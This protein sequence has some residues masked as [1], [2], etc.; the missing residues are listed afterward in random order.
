MTIY[1]IGI[2]V[3]NNKARMILIK[4]WKKIIDILTSFS[5][6]KLDFSL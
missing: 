4:Y 5:N 6:N 2:K 3:I 1:L